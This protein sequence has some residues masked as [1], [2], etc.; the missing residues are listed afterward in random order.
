MFYG[1]DGI[2]QNIFHIQPECEEYSVEYYQ[3]H[4]TLN[5]AMDRLVINDILKLFMNHK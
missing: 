4:I 1:T 5:N 3:S 2:L